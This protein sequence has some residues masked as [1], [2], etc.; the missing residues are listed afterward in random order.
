M[1]LHRFSW[2]LLVLAIAAGTIDDEPYTRP[3][4]TLGGYRVLAVDFHVHPFPLSA[5]T[6][7]PWDLVNE[8]RHQGL[9]AVAITGHNSAMPGRVARAL[10]SK[11]GDPTVL[12]GEEI[13]G[14]VYHMLAIGIEQSISWRLSAAQAIDEIHR[15]G[16]VAIA[17]HPGAA[18]WPAFA[19]DA[20][21][22]LDASEIVQPLIFGSERFTRE[23]RE[24]N[25]RGHFTA[26]G[27]SDY[28]GLGPVGICRTYVFA[29]DNTAASIL[30]ALRA[31]RTV[32]YGPGQIYGDPVLVA[33][34]S[35]NARLPDPQ[36][37]DGWF[38]VA[39]RI[40][41]MIGLI[42]VAFLTPDR[43][44][45]LNPP[46]RFSRSEYPAPRPPSDPQS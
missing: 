9:D 24:F 28:H 6:L 3:P 10:A 31:G 18:A 44:P 8:A 36:P 39:S 13:H 34:A 4:V 20:M 46:S 43:C 22:T 38:T 2:L 42:G 41:G 7:T 29:R 40:L 27:S 33:L 37:R 14:P 11:F 32:V 17:A 25:Q 26:T 30:E 16:G 21:R 45:A 19:G 15:Q 5:S 1:T 23:L 35:R 12:V